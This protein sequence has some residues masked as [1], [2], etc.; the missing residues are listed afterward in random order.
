MRILYGAQ[1]ICPSASDVA[2]TV[3]HPNGGSE[4]VDMGSRI[5]VNELGSVV[6]D[7]AALRY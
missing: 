3:Y 7:E 5:A 4:T 1:L 6:S 2:S